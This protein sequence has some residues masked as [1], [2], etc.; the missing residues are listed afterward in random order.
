M[1]FICLVSE[2]SKEN[3]QTGFGCSG[4][5]TVRGTVDQGWPGTSSVERPALPP[6]G[7][8]ALCS[9]CNDCLPTCPCSGHWASQKDR[10]CVLIISPPNP[11]PDTV[12]PQGRY[13]GSAGKG[14]KEDPMPK[15]CLRSLHGQPES[16]KFINQS[17][18]PKPEIYGIVPRK[19]I[20]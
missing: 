20:V 18:G 6:L 12:T 13:S 7:S 4:R 9:G 8:P 17:M 1:L 3:K 11:E 16:P 14:E 5:V 19:Q 2:P 10:D 15:P